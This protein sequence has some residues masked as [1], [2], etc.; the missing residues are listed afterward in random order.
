[1]TISFALVGHNTADI[2]QL[3]I[4]DPDGVMTEMGGLG[5]GTE[6]FSV[7][8]GLPSV[9]DG[10]NFF[11]WDSS[12]DPEAKATECYWGDADCNKAAYS[13]APGQAI[14][15]NCAEGLVVTAAGEV[16]SGKVEFV[17]GQ[18]NNFT[19]NPFPAT[20]DIQNIQ[21]SDPKG[22]MT[23]M[24]GLGWGTEVFSIWE[25]LPTVVDG[26]NFFYWDS[27]MDPEAKATECYWG[28]ADCNKVSYP[29]SAGQGVV[30][31]CAEGLTITVNLYSSVEVG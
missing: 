30:I 31:N 13:I 22:V 5:W 21:V 14:A 25:G 11:Y 24:G 10:S 26:S 18:D 7:W 1:M 4:S 3:K 6:V 12:M 9:V 15:L 23:E 27:S 2:Q 16:L 19:G 20:I 28:D 29:I 8:Q 17:S